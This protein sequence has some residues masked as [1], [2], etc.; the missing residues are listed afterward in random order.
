MA[1]SQ[2]NMH[3]V[4][5]SLTLTLEIPI[6]FAGGHHHA[7]RSNN[8]HTWARSGFLQLSAVVTGK[9]SRVSLYALRKIHAH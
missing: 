4:W 3:F 2:T 9:S 6:H 8:Q 1:F 7:R 5:R